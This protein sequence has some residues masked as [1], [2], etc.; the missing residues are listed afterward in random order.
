MIPEEFSLLEQ[1]L[2]CLE[3]KLKTLPCFHNF[4]D[5]DEKFSLVLS[6][7]LETFESK[8][9]KIHHHNVLFE[10]EK[11]LRSQFFDQLKFYRLT[12]SLPSSSKAEILLTCYESIL[13]SAKLLQQL[14]EL[15]KYAEISHFE[16]F[17]CV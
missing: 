4:S 11:T 3:I 8:L 10:L 6:K 13:T 7:T 5:Q 16:G 14:E 9:A 12:Q 15:K 17:P 2:R 1:R